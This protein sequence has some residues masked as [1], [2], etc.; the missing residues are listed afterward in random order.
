MS[1]VNLGVTH[2]W[3]L[4]QLW[5]KVLGGGSQVFGWPGGT[6]VVSIQSDFVT[7]VESRYW[8]SIIFSI[9]LIGLDSDT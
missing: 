6:N 9:L 5:C 7:N 4:W 8:K 2:V 3:K 1:G